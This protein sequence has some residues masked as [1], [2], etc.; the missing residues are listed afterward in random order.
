MIRTISAIAAL[1]LSAWALPV[2]TVLAEVPGVVVSIK[3]IHSLAA[4]VMRG[5]GE[6]TLLIE[7]GASPHSYSLKPSEAEALQNA[8]VVFWIGDGMEAF[9]E[10][11]LEA[12]PT[13]A[14]VVALDR[15]EGVVLLPSRDSGGWEAHADHDA[16]LEKDHGHGDGHD[17]GHAEKHDD[18]DDHG[19]ADEHADDHAGEHAHGAHDMHI[20]LDP[21]NAT[22]IVAR[23]VGVLSDVDPANATR[24]QANGETLKTRLAA[25]GSGIDGKLQPV[26]TTPYVVFHDAYQY[27]ENRYCLS[28]AGSITVDP[29]RKPSARRLVDIREKILDSGAV[30]VF[31]EPQFEPGVVVTVIEGTDARTG[32]L[33]PL[34]ADLPPG[35]DAYFALLENLAADLRSCLEPAV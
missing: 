22:A 30:C 28:P 17:H 14:R 10:K 33:D 2:G 25:L 35:P 7:G 32:V 4:G 23:M 29:D 1:S 26:R 21:T 20:W 13:H 5:I 8:D 16:E 3:P 12:L 31:S 6:P 24:Y 11:P 27:F 34:G 15:A 18:A 19:H 9:L